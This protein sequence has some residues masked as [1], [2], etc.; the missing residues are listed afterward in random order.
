MSEQTLT[1]LAILTVNWD[2]G[3]D[4]IE[5]F[6]PLV[7]DCIRRH[8]DQPISRVDLQSMVRV[9]A[10]I[11][12]PSGALEAI[13]GRCAKHGLIKKKQKVYFPQPNK[14]AESDYAPNQAEALRRHSCLLGKLRSFANERYG[15]EWSEDDADSHLLTFLQQGSVPVLAAAT[16]G[17]PLP[18]SN[19]EHSAKA[20]HVLSSFAQHVEEAG[21][22]GLRVPRNG[23]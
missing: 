11:K 19:K 15:L 14:L 4:A 22:R 3:H 7:A 17:D 8:G 16:E 5:S 9:E 1:S 21:C 23:R 2:R 10:G 18:R 20:K 6:V 13:L 12:I